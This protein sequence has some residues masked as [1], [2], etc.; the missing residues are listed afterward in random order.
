MIRRLFTLTVFTTT[1]TLAAFGQHVFGREH[2]AAW[3]QRVQ[4]EGP[5]QAQHAWQETDKALAQLSPQAGQETNDTCWIG[6]QSPGVLSYYQGH[7]HAHGR[8]RIQL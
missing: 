2:I 1:I 6:L 7:G 5:K 4:V 3:A 8:M